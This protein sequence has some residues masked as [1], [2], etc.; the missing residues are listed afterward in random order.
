MENLIKNCLLFK[1]ALKVWRFY[2][3]KH[4]EHKIRAKGEQCVSPSESLNL[5]ITEI[6]LLH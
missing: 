6:F 1:V 5:N 3:S 2:K 4:K